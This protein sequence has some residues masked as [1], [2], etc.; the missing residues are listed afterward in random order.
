[1]IFGVNDYVRFDIH[2]NDM[3]QP[4]DVV[5][6]TIMDIEACVWWTI[7]HESDLVKW[8]VISGFQWM[9]SWK[10][11][12]TSMKRW[13]CDTCYVILWAI[14]W[15]H[16]VFFGGHGLTM[17]FCLFEGEGIST[18]NMAS[19]W[20]VSFHGYFTAQSRPKGLQNGGAGRSTGQSV[21]FGLDPWFFSWKKRWQLDVPNKFSFPKD[22]VIFC[23]WIGWSDFF[24]SNSP[25]FR[26]KIH[27]FL[28]IFATKTHLTI[29]SHWIW[30]HR[31]PLVRLVT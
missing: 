11:H 22:S 31:S 19:W 10:H 26:V 23:Q 16:S 8:R 6:G 9:H 24:F 15:E 1:M 12:D 18:I 7:D 4:T 28:S 13:S 3:K 27:G 20:S 17:R 25:W 21:D 29:L 2:S 5:N 30:N 14:H